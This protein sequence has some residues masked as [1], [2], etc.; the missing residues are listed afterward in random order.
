MNVML[1][2][3]MGPS[4]NIGLADDLTVNTFEFDT[5]ANVTTG[6]ISDFSTT[7]AM[8]GAIGLFEQLTLESFAVAVVYT[9]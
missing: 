8:S 9:G 5:T 6:T 7:I 2:D 1:Q 4:T 3:L